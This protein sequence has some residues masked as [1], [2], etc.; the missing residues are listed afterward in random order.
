MTPGKKRK[1][2]IREDKKVKGMKKGC[3]LE[4]KFSSFENIFSKQASAILVIWASISLSLSISLPQHIRMINAKFK[5][6]VQETFSK[7]KSEM[8]SLLL[9]FKFNEKHF[10][11]SKFRLS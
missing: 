11:K 3:E 7:F 8:F 1:G 9:N 6:F 5:F 2:S 4:I 10:K